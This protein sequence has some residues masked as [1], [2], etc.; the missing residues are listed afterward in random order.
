MVQD[1][2]GVPFSTDVAEAPTRTET[3]Q[4]SWNEEPMRR[5]WAAPRILKR[6]I[7]YRAGSLEM[8]HRNAWDVGGERHPERKASWPPNGLEMSRPASQG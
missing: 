5:G 3:L 8:D 4:V 2:I 6:Q 1:A 7:D